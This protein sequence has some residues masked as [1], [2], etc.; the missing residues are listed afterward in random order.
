MTQWPLLCTIGEIMKKE[1]M[2]KLKG[3]LDKGGDLQAGRKG[4]NFWGRPDIWRDSSSNKKLMVLT[5]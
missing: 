2:A 3:I 5:R 1:C 4:T